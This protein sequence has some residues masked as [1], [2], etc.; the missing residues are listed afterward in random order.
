MATDT[1]APAA[2]A[3]AFTVIKVGEDGFV[4][5]S[6]EE[7]RPVTAVLGTDAMLAEMEVR[8]GP[9]PE[10]GWTHRSLLHRAGQRGTSSF[11]TSTARRL[12]ERNTLGDDGE[13]L[14]YEAVAKRFDWPRLTPPQEPSPL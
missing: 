11:T 12:V 14:S 9:S 6:G 8:L 7:G 13:A 3:R 10:I 1:D 5:W 2:E 4:G